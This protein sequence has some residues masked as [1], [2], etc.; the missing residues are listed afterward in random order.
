M[1]TAATATFASLGARTEHL[2]IGPGRAGAELG[3]VLRALLD[4]LRARTERT[5]HESIALRRANERTRDTLN[6]QAQRMR[7]LAGRPVV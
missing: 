3:R 2:Y 4:R 1:S 6:A 5:S 7:V